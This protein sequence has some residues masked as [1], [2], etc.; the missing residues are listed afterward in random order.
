[1]LAWILAAGAA[2]CLAYYIVIVAYAGFGTSFACIWLL[3]G[4]FLGL[5]AA[6]FRFYQK[7]P[8]RMELWIPVSMVT[9]CASGLVIFLVVQILMFGR[10]PSVAEP[11]LDYVVVLGASVKED[12]PSKTLQLRLDKAAEYARENP[13][14]VLVL[15]GAKG[16]GE[17]VSEAEAMADYL[18]DKGIPESQLL[19]EMRSAS[20][21]ENLAYSRIAIDQEERQKEA[22]RREKLEFGPGFA[23]KPE[24]KPVR[25]GILTSNFHLFRARMIA[26]KQGWE[27]L[28]GIAAES[29]PILFVHFCF[30]D[31]LAILKD[32]LVGNL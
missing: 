27:D 22:E 28:K 6:S 1:M 16:K 13:G 3:F 21:T 8:D 9:L 7:H 14:T 32:R 18:I 5:T 25:I 31:S 30:R 23:G 11:G 24:N 12:G 19:L 17:P 2:F 4:G 29:D 15:S 26:K 20:T 10:I